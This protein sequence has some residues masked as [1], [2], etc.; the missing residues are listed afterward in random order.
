MQRLFKALVGDKSLSNVILVTTMW[1]LVDEATGA[2]RERELVQNIDYW[3]GLIARGA[4]HARFTATS[5]SGKAIIGLLRERPQ[6]DTQVQTQMVDEGLTVAETSAGII[7][8]TELEAMRLETQRMIA[9]L[10]EEHKGALEEGN[11]MMMEHIL[12]ERETYEKRIKILE[13]KSRKLMERP[14]YRRFGEAVL[15]IV[16]FGLYDPNRWV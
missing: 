16:S 1:G 9:N 10:K 7:V 8:S 12:K 11:R 15:Q 2:D 13:E 14:W 4:R 5:E 3:A 6:M